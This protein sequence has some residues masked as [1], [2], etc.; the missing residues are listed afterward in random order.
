LRGLPKKM[1]H[2]QKAKPMKKF[3][4]FFPVALALSGM[5]CAYVELLFWGENAMFNDLGVHMPTYIYVSMAILFVVGILNFYYFFGWA[6]MS[7]KKQK[8]GK[9]LVAVNIGLIILGGIATHFS[10][11]LMNNSI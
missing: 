10:T 3:S 7:A 4:A 6:K 1:Y 5:A 11:Y 8:Q 9:I 2:R